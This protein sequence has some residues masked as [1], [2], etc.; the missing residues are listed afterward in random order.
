MILI[1]IDLHLESQASSCFQYGDKFAE[2]S[3]NIYACNI[4]R[5]IS[6][7]KN[8][9][10]L[11]F[12]GKMGNLSEIVRDIIEI[13]LFFSI[14]VR[15]QSVFDIPGEAWRRLDSPPHWTRW[16]I[17]EFCFLPYLS[18]RQK[19]RG[20]FRVHV[21]KSNSLTDNKLQSQIMKQL[22]ID[23]ASALLTQN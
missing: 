18:I 7:V 22:D 14:D 12:F 19:I 4:G 2:R 13:L 6:I 9:I 15:L 1:E 23:A 16:K 20:V 21:F 10:S 11:S 8:S 17:L 3:K 5:G